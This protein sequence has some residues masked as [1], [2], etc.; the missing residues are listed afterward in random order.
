MIK[1]QWR[2]FKQRI[3]ELRVVSKNCSDRILQTKHS[4]YKPDNHWE[5]KHVQKYNALNGHTRDG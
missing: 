3:L 5:P 1:Y 4:C 2:T